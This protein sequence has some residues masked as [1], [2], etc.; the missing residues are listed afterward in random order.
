MAS[1]SSLVSSPTPT[2]T[3]AASVPSIVRGTRVVQLIETP[4]S[5]LV[6]DCAY[7]FGNR[8]A[9]CVPWQNI[10]LSYRTL[11]ERSR[12]M[13][14]LLLGA[15]LK[16]GNIIGIMAGNRYEY[17]ET[18][19]AGGRIG[20][21]VV[22]MNNMFSPSELEHAMGR[23]N[24]SVL[25]IASNIGPRNME[26]HIKCALSRPD[27]PRHVV[28][29]G[30]DKNWGS[31]RACHYDSFFADANAKATDMEL[32]A[33][34]SRVVVNDILN[35][36][37]TSGTTGRPKAA[38]LTHR[39]ILNDAMFVGAAMKLTP[40][41]VVSCPP[42]LFHCFGLVMG[43]LASFYHGSSIVLPSDTF[44]AEKTIESVLRERVTALLGV[45]TMFFAQLEL[46]DK[47]KGRF[48]PFTTV[49]TGLAAGAQVPAQLMNIIL[50]RMNIPSLLIAYGMTETSPV[51]FITAIEDTEEKRFNTIGRVL[52]HTDAKV[53]NS[54]GR[55]L[56]IGQRGEICTA[57]FP[58]QRGYW[59]D[60]E[61][62]RD[63][64]HEDE[65]GVRWMHT[66]D[67]GYLDADGY[68]Y[69]TGRIKDLI[70]R[71]GE[72][73]SPSEIEG[74]L[75]EHPLIGESCVVGLED[76]KY[77]EA[78]ACFLK[79][80]DETQGCRPSDVELRSWVSKTLGR[81][82]EPKHVFWVG[83]EGV[84]NDLI[85]TASGKYQKHLIRAL[86]N[87]LLKKSSPP[88]AKL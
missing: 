76:K 13:A 62:T 4:L 72:N 80:S 52:P 77:G 19:L 58:L 42:P 26:E 44:N 71:G 68:G 10:N 73:I 22:L 31:D 51:T 88:S 41:D 21:P 40:V 18:F 35:L 27:G 53:V 5:S 14:K 49:R 66:G 48:A 56:P 84:G 28:V 45:P 25:V 33:A 1:S 46:L 75:L 63:V 81:H 24:V 23:V 74:R 20:C 7:R 11:A 39:N 54:R 83:D 85:K 6:E 50:K 43:F 8:T 79:A 69:V 55:I 59:H 82:K 15:G 32:A 2:P 12:M 86:G 47:Q 3:A 67:E 78:V 65:H 64:M 38:C 9:V 61:K 29:L 57:G 36:Q 60:E 70:I 37:F 34:E 87:G 16:Y 30:D 17:I